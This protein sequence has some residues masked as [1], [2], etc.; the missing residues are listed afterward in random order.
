MEVWVGIGFWA[1]DEFLEQ[2]RHR[3]NFSVH[4]GALLT[5]GLCKMGQYLYRSTNVAGKFKMRKTVP[6]HISKNVL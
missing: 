6:Y 1:R 3:F 2:I 4:K 5:Q